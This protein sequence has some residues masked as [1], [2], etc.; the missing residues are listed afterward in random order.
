MLERCADPGGAES[1]HVGLTNLRPACL[2][3]VGG[4]LL[5]LCPACYTIRNKP[6]RETSKAPTESNNARKMMACWSPGSLPVCLT[7]CRGPEMFQNAE[8]FA[9]S[10]MMVQ[11]MV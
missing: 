8:T 4:L 10:D 7:A 2:D 6:D 1:V 11:N 5:F 3:S 9:N